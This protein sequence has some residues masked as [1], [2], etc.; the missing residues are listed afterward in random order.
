MGVPRPRRE[1][2]SGGSV[3]PPKRGSAA[4]ALLVLASPVLA[5]VGM[6]YYHIA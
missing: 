2:Q 4:I 6:V 3:K 5:A 1:G